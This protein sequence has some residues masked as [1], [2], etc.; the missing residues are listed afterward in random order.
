MS[1]KI[2]GTGS[3]LPK[4]SVT[5]DFLSTIMDT[6][7]EWIA[8]RTG[9]RAR[10]LVKEETSNSMACEAAK[11]ALLDAGKTAED[12]DLIIVATISPDQVMPSTACELQSMLGAVHAFCFDLSAAC[13]GFLYALS[14][15]AAYMK[16]GMSHCALIVGVE[17]LSKIMDWNDRGTCV[18][19]GDG[20]GACVVTNDESRT[21]ESIM[22]SDGSLG[23]V[24]SLGAR[25]NNNP[26]VTSEDQVPYVYMD[27]Q[28]V[29][30]FAVKKV[31]ACIKDVLF[32]A[33]V[34]VDE[35][36]YFVLHQANER[37]LASVAK[38]LHVD[39]SKFPMNL[40]Q[41]GNTSSAT[42]PILLDEMNQ[43]G[44]L[45]R[46][47]KIVLCGFGGGLTWGASFLEW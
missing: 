22:A 28:A 47:D 41:C 8:S 17:T 2:A 1:I 3:S 30:K 44:M 9:I 29:Y 5:N 33:E 21:Y 14:T 40:D 42:I 15:A 11:K 38:R 37:I 25:G 20:A 32:K 6:S 31:P 35:I 19:F 45:E 39:L 34:S 26:L 18:L 24:L 12:L 36:K 27:G 43:K 7:D 23:H 16:S 46:G 13:S 4:E 10:H